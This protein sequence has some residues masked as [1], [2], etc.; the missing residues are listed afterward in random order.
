[1]E[2]ARARGR[3][4]ALG[5]AGALPVLYAFGVE[6]TWI[7]VT[8]HRVDAPVDPPLT[9]AHLS[10][11]HTEGLGRRER[12]LLERLD[13]EKPD[14]IVVTGDSLN[15]QLFGPRPGRHDEVAYARAAGFLGRLHAPLGV[16]VVRGNWEEL[17]R[18]PD[19]RGYYS[20]LGL[21]FLVN[22]AAEMRPG[23]W[24]AGFDDSKGSP[25]LEP[26]LRAIPADARFTI[27]LFHSPAYFDRLKGRFP[28]ALAGHTHGGQVRLPFLPPLWLPSGC[29]RYVEGWYESGGSRLYVS[30]GIG[31]SVLPIRFF[32][33]PELAFITVGRAADSDR[34]GRTAPDRPGG[35]A[36]GAG[37]ATVRAFAARPGPRAAPGPT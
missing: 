35:P 18:L 25:Q 31:T 29:G 2:R 32:C 10:D 30:R 12:E 33:R 22:E 34:A 17:R 24:V 1:M 36:T 7:E 28:L 14:A 20:R 19:E 37:A 8:R 23:V 9:I 15:G 16:W 4:A 26:A 13:A 21:R 5:F 3:L 6:P 27:A 11:L